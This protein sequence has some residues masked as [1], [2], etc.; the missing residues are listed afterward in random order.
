[1]KKIF[2]LMLSAAL[3]FSMA[4]CSNTQQNDAPDP[5]SSEEPS[6]V[7]ESTPAEVT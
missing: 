5:V 6:Q 2:A 1:M 7:E 3:V 4:A